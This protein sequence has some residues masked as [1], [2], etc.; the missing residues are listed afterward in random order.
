MT[1]AQ[2]SSL[3]N[4]FKAHTGTD[5]DAD[6]GGIMALVFGIILGVITG[7]ALIYKCMQ[8]KKVGTTGGNRNGTIVMN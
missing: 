8:N 6:N 4:G 1:P 3:A 2:V 5:D 7:V